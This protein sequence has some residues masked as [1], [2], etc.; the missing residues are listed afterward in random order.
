MKYLKILPSDKC[1]IVGLGNIRSTPDSLGVK[2]LNN[3]LV[4]RYLFEIDNIS[5]NSNF[6]NVSV[7]APGVSGNTGI[8]SFDII[9]AI[10]KETKPDFIIVID[11]LVSSSSER[12]VKTIQ[13]TTTGIIPGSGIN[14]NKKEISFD[15]LNIPVITLGVP[16]V[17]NI[18]KDKYNL[19]VTPKDIDFLIE[20]LSSIISKSLNRVLHK[21]F[22][23]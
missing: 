2:T 7:I 14:S 22:D 18:I 11:S 9:S 15:V 12:L 20:K 21:N 5:V 1:L 6:R 19:L 8:D 23:I 3:I 4:T 10:I 13:I 17:I 16:T